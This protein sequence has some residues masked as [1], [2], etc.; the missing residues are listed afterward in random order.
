MAFLR[1]QITLLCHELHDLLFG[2]EGLQPAGDHDA[3]QINAGERGRPMSDHNND[4]VSLP[5]AQY[6]PYQG[7]FAFRVEI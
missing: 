4:P 6:R 2:S 3:H 1:S 5:Y 7:I